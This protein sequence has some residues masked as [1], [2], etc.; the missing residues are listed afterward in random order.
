MLANPPKL[1]HVAIRYH[2]IRDLVE[3]GEV[4]LD[5][6]AGANNPADILTK[7]LNASKFKQHAHRITVGIG[8]GR[9]ASLPK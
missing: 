6:V 3:K 9:G 2:F 5:W 1:R 4:A 7:P 8:G